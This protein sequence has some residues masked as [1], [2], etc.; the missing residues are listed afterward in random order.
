M[1]NSRLNLPD[2]GKGWV[3]I[4]I[5]FLPDLLSSPCTKVMRKSKMAAVMIRMKLS[6]WMIETYSSN[7]FQLYVHNEAHTDEIGNDALQS[8]TST[9][10]L[11][12]L[13][14]IC[15]TYM[16]CMGMCIPLQDNACSKEID[17]LISQTII[18]SCTQ[19]LAG[20][21]SK[22]KWGKSSSNQNSSRVHK[23]SYY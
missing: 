11:S 16:Q 13:H 4:V 15:H 18:T 21:N 19:F 7:W 20:I 12:T 10:S 8:S 17:V 3:G 23:S 1:S 6:D 2:F 9:A 22:V 14:I 5:A